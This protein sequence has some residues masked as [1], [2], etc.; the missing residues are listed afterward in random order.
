AGA[1]LNEASDNLQRTSIYAPMSG[2]ISLLAVELGER[3]VGTQQMA[4]TELLRVADLSSMEVE[5]DVNENDIVKIEVG[6][7]AI[8]EVDAYLKKEFEGVVTEIANTASG[9][10]T[11]D[12][13]TNFKV[14]VRILPES[15]TDLLEGKSEN[16][17]PF[18]PGMTA[19]VDI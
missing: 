11:A 15:Y 9:Q 12:Q 7:K 2:T 8:V 10:L 4:G 3:V 1:T 6:D 5:V 19:T 18:K 13:V 16:Y 17:S 14:K